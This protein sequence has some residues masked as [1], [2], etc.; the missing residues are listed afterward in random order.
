MAGVSLPPD[1]L[2]ERHIRSWGVTDAETI[3]SIR[4]R[5]CGDGKS[6]EA[7]TLAIDSAVWQKV[8]PLF[9]Q[10]G[11]RREQA[12]ALVKLACLTGGLG[13]DGA[14]FANPDPEER[15]RL[16]AR[17]NKACDKYRLPPRSTAAVPTQTIAVFNPADGALRRIKNLFRQVL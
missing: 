14:I 4:E 10:S 3:Q 9:A 1:V 12:L 2:A 15:A 16:A 8:A 6:L 11:L 7:V 13:R 5:L 17:I